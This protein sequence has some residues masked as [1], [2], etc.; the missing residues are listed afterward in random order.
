M[1]RQTKSLP[2]EPI[3]VTV[4]S[5]TTL[6]RCDKEAAQAE[7]TEEEWEALD[8]ELPYQIVDGKVVVIPVPEAE[9]PLPPEKQPLPPTLEILYEQ[10][11]A[12]LQKQIEA[13]WQASTSGDGTLLKDIEA[14]REKA[15]QE[16]KE[17][18]GAV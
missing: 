12:G 7:L 13:L 2:S 9:A 5:G 6:Y 10:R 18:G 8:K 11:E 3:Y 16:W 17:R 15:R 4:F 1:A 14:R